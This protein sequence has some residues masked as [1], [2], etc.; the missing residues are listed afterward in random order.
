MA[1]VAVIKKAYDAKTFPN[2]N[3]FVGQ[4][5]LFTQYFKPYIYG[6]YRY[7]EIDLKNT[8]S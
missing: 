8:M 4:F 1:N 6:D 7:K 2:C 3:A 5:Y